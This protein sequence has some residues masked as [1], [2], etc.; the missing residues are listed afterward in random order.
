MK[1]Q[2]I[3]GSIRQGRVSDKVAHWT[4]KELQSL[5]NVEAEIVDLV[6][7]PMPLFDEVAPPQYNPARTPRPEVKKWLDK[8]AEADAFVLVTPEYNRSFPGALKNALDYIDFQFAKKPIAL[9]AH[10]SAGGA[11]AVASLRITL[12]QMLAVTVPS[13]TL[14]VGRAGEMLDDSGELTDEQA[15]ANPYGVQGSLKTT[16]A[17]LQWYGEA[18]ATARAAE[19]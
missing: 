14:F 19:Q 10:G 4:L 7:Y 8:L 9:V 13:A 3:S 11:Q 18:L 12:P 17:E 16:L 6:D 1:V 15:K 2:V 5:P